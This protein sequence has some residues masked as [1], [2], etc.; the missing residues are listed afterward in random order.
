MYDRKYMKQKT[1]SL[2]IWERYDSYNCYTGWGAT[3]VTGSLDIETLEECKA[4]C[5]KYEDCT[6]VMFNILNGWACFLRKDI[7]LSK[8]FSGPGYEMFALFINTGIQIKDILYLTIL[9]KDK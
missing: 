1:F 2:G 7:E 3:D 6:A 8:C 5:L 4:E 9:N